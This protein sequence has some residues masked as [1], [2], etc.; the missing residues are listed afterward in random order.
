MTNRERL[1]CK[2][3]ETLRDYLVHIPRKEWNAS[4]VFLVEDA[5]TSASHRV[6][7]DVFRGVKHED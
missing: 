2:A 3:M 5:R 7:Q 6:A 1:R 4:I